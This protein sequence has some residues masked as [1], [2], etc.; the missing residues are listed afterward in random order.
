MKI[1]NDYLCRQL[2]GGGMEINMEV[3]IGYLI[4]INFIAFF[5][6]GLDKRKAQKNRWRITEK[7]LIGIAVIGGS[8]GAFT[9]MKLFRHKTK[10][11]KFSFGIPLVILMQAILIGYFLLNR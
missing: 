6:Y 3:L 11:R 2:K 1:F 9:G 4:I 10:K 8:L 7:T 5:L